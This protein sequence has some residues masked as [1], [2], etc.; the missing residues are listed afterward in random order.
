MFRI[1]GRVAGGLLAAVTTSAGLLTPVVPAQ[2]AYRHDLHAT[3]YGASAYP[4]A[5]GGAE[6]HSGHHMGREFEVRI[7][8]IQGIDASPRSTVNTSWRL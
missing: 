7:R 2:V 8:G 4:N 3:L 1:P 6:Y 5:R